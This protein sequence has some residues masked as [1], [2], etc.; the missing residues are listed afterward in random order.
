LRAYSD[1][2][3]ENC[4]QLTLKD[5]LELAAWAG[6]EIR[7]D[8]KGHIPAYQSPILELLGMNSAPVMA[9]LK[10]EEKFFPVAIG[11]VSLI[12]Q[13]ASSLGRRFIKRVSF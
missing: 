11:P 8:K 1:E 9:Y 7:R 12:R 6:R 13:F 4:L 10:H 5:Y 2:S 3:S